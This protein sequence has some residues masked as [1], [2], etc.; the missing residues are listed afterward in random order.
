MFVYVD[1]FICFALVVSVVSTHVDVFRCCH[2]YVV[3]LTLVEDVDSN[4]VEWSS[5]FWHRYVLATRNYHHIIC[6]ISLFQYRIINFVR[7]FRVTLAALMSVSPSPN[8]AVEVN[9][10]YLFTTHMCWRCEITNISLHCSH[11]HTTTPCTCIFVLGFQCMD[12][13]KTETMV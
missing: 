10:M 9:G 5:L 13:V 11:S 8:P 4:C 7:S 1:E 2:C 12:Y 6:S 3:T